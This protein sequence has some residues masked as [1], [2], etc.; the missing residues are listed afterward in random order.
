MRVTTKGRY[1]L[2][3]MLKLAASNDNRPISIRALVEGEDI[4]PE[5]LEQ[6]FFKLKKARVVNST[7]GPG[8][9]FQ[10]N[11]S[12]AEI[13]VNEILD[14]AGEGIGLS[15]C[16]SETN[17]SVLC[18][19]YDNCYVRMFWENATNHMREYFSGIT[20]KSILDKYYRTSIRKE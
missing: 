13:T 17:D 7:R 19:K 15:P 9:G 11:K 14:A 12:A 5:F 4:S 3:A 6:I 20:L 18:S 1:A 2:R 10:L 8:G 16:T